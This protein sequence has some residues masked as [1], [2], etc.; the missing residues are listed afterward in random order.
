M[1]YKTTDMQLATVLSL[2]F[3][4]KELINH[5]NRGTFVF[6]DSTELRDLITGFYDKKLSVEPKALFDNLKNIK[7]RL[8]STVKEVY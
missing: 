2:N 3:P 1:N 6:E 8:Y 4:I 7:D 5:E